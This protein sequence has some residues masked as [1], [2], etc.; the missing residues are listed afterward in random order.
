MAARR[1]AG[2]EVLGLVDGRPADNRRQDLDVADVFGVG[3]KRVAVQD[4]EVGELSGLERA[5]LVLAVQREGGPLGVEGECV[6]DRE[7]LGWS[8]HAAF[9]CAAQDGIADTDERVGGDDWGVG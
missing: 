2:E 9:G 8:E 5:N 6:Q 7:A 3:V 1:S 4:N